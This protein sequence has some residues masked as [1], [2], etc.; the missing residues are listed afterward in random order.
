MNIREVSISDFNQWVRLRY[1]LWPYHTVEELSEEM[2][3]LYSRINSDYI[4]Y[5][6]EDNHNIV[7]FI[8]V[9]I[10][11]NALGCKTKNVGFIEGWYVKAEYRQRGVG[12][13]LVEKSEV[14]AINKGCI[15]MASDTNQRYPVSQTAHKALGYEEVDSSFNFK[16]TLIK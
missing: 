5:L 4:F 16:K 11:E 15:E 14:W 12:R 1:L 7:G 10:H 2:E 9:S 13:L 8:E 6:A 3:K